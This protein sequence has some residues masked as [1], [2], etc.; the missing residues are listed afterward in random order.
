MNTWYRYYVLY[1]HRQPLERIHQVKDLGFLS[2]PPLDFR[3]HIDFVAGKARYVSSALLGL[4]RHFS[5][6]DNPK[7]LY[8]PYNSYM[9]SLLEY[10]AITWSPYTVVTLRDLTESKPASYKLRRVLNVAHPPHDYGDH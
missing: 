8:I 6:F 5:N 1:I 2:V 9:R 4:R 10:G 3:P 7:C